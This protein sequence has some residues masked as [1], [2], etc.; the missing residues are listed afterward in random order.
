MFSHKSFLLIISIFSILHY[1]SFTTPVIGI[2]GGGP[3]YSGGNANIAKNINDLKASGFTKVILWSVHVYGNGDLVYNDKKI[4]SQGSYV[5]DAQWPSYLKT[6]KSGQTS[7]NQ[8]YLSVGSAGVGD[9][10]SVANLIKTQGTSPSSILY[11]N[12]MALRLALPDVEGIDLDDED[13][14]DHD[15]IV[16]FSVLLGKIGFKVS[17]CPY[18]GQDFWIS[19]LK[20]VQALA[21]NVVS[22]FNL[23]CYA[24]GSGNDPNTWQQAINKS[25]VKIPVYPG[26]AN[27]ESSTSQIQS[28]FQKWKNQGITGGFMWLYDGILK[29]G[30]PTAKFATAIKNGL[31]V[32]GLQK[33]GIVKRFKGRV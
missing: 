22:H 33:K 23:Q 32:A 4:A 26:R 24:G 30:I 15:T 3:L 10:A 17:F 5:G 12:F 28:D 29:S 20:D 8:I 2:Y 9:F 21:P 19:C 18:Y 16:Q 25:G 7:V 6:L 31:S 13:Y 11:K 27:S 14:V 1:V